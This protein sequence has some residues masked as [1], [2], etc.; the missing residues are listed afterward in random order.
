MLFDLI[1]FFTDFFSKALD[2]HNWHSTGYLVLLGLL[3]S[4][5]TS[6]LYNKTV[7]LTSGLFASSVTYIM[8]II[9]VMWGVLDDEKITVQHFVGMGVILTGIYLINKK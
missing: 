7:Q 4:G 8:P 5:I 9:A 6:I 2:I 1:L 3:G